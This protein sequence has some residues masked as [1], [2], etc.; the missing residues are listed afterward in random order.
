MAEEI[1]DCMS[2]RIFNVE[3]LTDALLFTVFR[4]NSQQWY[5]KATI[6]RESATKSCDYD[7]S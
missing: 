6:G 1:L 2:M 3:E 5:P 7:R 4:H